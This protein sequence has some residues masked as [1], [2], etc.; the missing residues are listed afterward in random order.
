MEEDRAARCLAKPVVRTPDSIQGVRKGVQPW[1]GLPSSQVR[2]EKNSSSNSSHEGCTDRFLG[3]CF[4]S[5]VGITVR[6]TAVARSS[7]KDGPRA[8]VRSEC[9]ASLSELRFRASAG[10]PFTKRELGLSSSGAGDRVSR[11]LTPEWSLRLPSVPAPGHV[12]RESNA[13]SG[14]VTMWSISGPCSSSP[15]VWIDQFRKTSAT[16]SAT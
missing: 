8:A 16:R 11:Q 15:A 14:F 4:P 3:T 7:G 6:S 2:H 12:S 1:S 5:V 9:P 13:R 10:R